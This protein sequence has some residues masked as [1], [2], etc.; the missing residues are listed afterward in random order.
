MPELIFELR[1]LPTLWADER[2]MRRIMI[3]LL[4]NAIKFNVHGGSV[5]V[6][7]LEAGDFIKI[8]V[9]DTG[10]G[11][12]ADAL[13]RVLR[14]FEQIDNHYSR[15]L[16]GTGLGLSIVAGLVALQNGSL[17]LASTVGKGTAVTV[18]IPRGVKSPAPGLPG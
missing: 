8:V 18:R 4:G 16:G 1:F 17:S 2:A 12:P 3:N 13:E 5:L 14:P 6:T 10:T 15:T 11:I 9:A 7:A